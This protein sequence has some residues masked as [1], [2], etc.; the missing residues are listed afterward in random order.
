MKR[1]V[2]TSRAGNGIPKS[3]RDEFDQLF[4]EMQG[5]TR[6]FLEAFN[7]SPEQ[8]A[9]AAVEAARKAARSSTARRRRRK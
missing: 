1:P 4:V 7:A 5:K 3:L 2:R 6:A 8:L 9:K